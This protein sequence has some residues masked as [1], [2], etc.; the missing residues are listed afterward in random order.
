VAKDPAVVRE[1]H[2]RAAAAPNISRMVP[3]RGRFMIT[4]AIQ[5]QGTELAK[6]FP[7]RD[8]AAPARPAVSR[9]SLVS[10]DSPG[11]IKLELEPSHGEIFVNDATVE[12]RGTGT[13][14]QLACA[15]R[16]LKG[17]ALEVAGTTPGDRVSMLYPIP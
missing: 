17:L 15:C 16:A 10:P 5:L 6:C 11:V 3:S 12:Q 7:G 1:A 14:E 13:A 2:A 8:L 4:R 9:R